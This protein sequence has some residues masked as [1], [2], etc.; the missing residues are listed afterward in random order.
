MEYRYASLLRPIGCWVYLNQNFRI[1]DPLESDIDP[2]NPDWP[3]HNVLVSDEPLP[4]E[5]IESLQ[6]TDVAAMKERKRLYDLLNNMS[7][8]TR[9]ARNEVLI[10]EELGDK[11]RVGKIKNEVVLKRIVEKYVNYV[12]RM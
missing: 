9:V 12:N 2:F 8:D 4:T 11:I 5:K 7:L 1:E 6:L 10:K 3:A